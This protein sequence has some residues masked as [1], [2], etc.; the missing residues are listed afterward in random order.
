MR[1]LFIFLCLVPL[2]TVPSRA[3]EGMWLIN[4]IRQLN[5]GD[6]QAMGLELD[7]GDI[8]STV[9]PSLKDAIGA[10]DHGSCTAEIISPNGLIITN[11]HCGYGEIQ[12][13]SSLGHDYLTDGFW[14]GSMEE[15][16]PNPGKTISFLVRMEDVTSRLN[17]Q[18]DPGMSPDARA[19]R[20]TELSRRL[21]GEA[22]SGT[23]YEGYIYPMFEG[24]SYFLVLVE[25]FRDVRLVGAPPSSIGKFGDETDNWEWPRHTGDFS[26]FRIYTGPDGQPADYSP[27]NIPY[28]PPYFLRVTKEGIR[29][30]DFTMVLGYP[31]VTSRYLTRAEIKERMEVDNRVRIQVG[32]RA[33]AIMKSEMNADGEVRIRYAEKYA[34]YSNYLKFSKGE[35]RS[36]RQLGVLEEQQNKEDAF[37][38]WVNSDP[39]RRSRYGHVLEDIR[40][41]VDERAQLAWPR[42]CLEEIFL[43]Y[44]PVEFVDFPASSFELYL[45]LR[46]DR[47]YAGEIDSLVAE[48]SQK[49]D[50]YFADYTPRVDKKIS[51]A[52]L[53]YLG[54]HVDPAYQPTF[55]DDLRDKPADQITEYLDKVFRRSIFTDRDRFFRFLEHPKLKGLER[56]PVFDMTRSLYGKYF[57][58]D[59]LYR[60]RSTGMEEN[61]RLYLEGIMKMMKDRTFYPDANSTLRLSYGRVSGYNP[62]DAVHYKFRTTLAGV[63]EKEE[64]GNPEFTVPAK[65]KNI[66][67]EKD[68]GD[69]APGDTMFVCFITDNDITG[70]NSGSPV[71][72]AR[73]DL[74][75]LAFD[76]NWEA[77]SSNIAYV[78]RLQK[79]I[80]VDIRYVLL[81]I[82]RFAGAGWLLNE[83]EIV[84]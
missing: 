2:L 32:S 82:D 38:A 47:E 35:N 46:G 77:M 21:I 61:R 60:S 55:M 8:Y 83:M 29:R 23:P 43:L 71:L 58:I 72:N 24:N 30:G 64:P 56:D 63:M 67:R 4:L 78:P 34:A 52:M 20:I 37:S 74:V 6:M 14:A 9:H 62:R 51:A 73:G 12:S 42:A 27:D 81:V 76:G 3:D 40:T 48:L 22:T 65:L 5:L 75:G 68:Y 39:E 36:L 79:C 15:E 28:H 11:H 10:L 31:G 7:A 50:A 84:E 80:C 54:K 41:M 17:A 70:G 44:K 69:Y 66:Y 16:L 13:H 18:L 57:E 1:R 49:A 53:E 45:A 26:L 33:L 25:T 19:T 59:D